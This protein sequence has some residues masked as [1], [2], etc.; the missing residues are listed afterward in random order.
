MYVFIS[1]LKYLGYYLDIY[2]QDNYRIIN[3]ESPELLSGD[4]PLK[5][6]LM[7]SDGPNRPSDR[8]LRMHF[9][10]SL[11]VSA[12]GGDPRDDYKEQE[13]DAFMEELG[14]YDDAIDY[15]DPRWST[16]LGMEV[17]SYLIRQSLAP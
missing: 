10:R 8:F 6:H 9:E 3:F 15:S 12:Y 5:T 11:A 13:I 2:N 17:H 7:L 16:S 14:I 1:V 4:A